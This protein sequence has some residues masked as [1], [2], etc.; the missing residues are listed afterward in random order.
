MQWIEFY[1]RQAPEI[2]KMLA[3]AQA[4]GVQPPLDLWLALE[5]PETSYYHKHCMYNAGLALAQGELV[6]F[7]DSDAMLKPSFVRSLIAAFDAEEDIVLHVDEVRNADQSFHPFRHPSFEEVLGPGC[8]NWDGEKTT[9]LSD[10]RTPLLTRNYGACMC[11]QRQDLIAVGGADEHLDYMGHV[12]GPYD[13]TFRL[14]N[15]GKREVW[16]QSE[17]LYHVWHPGTD[18]GCNYIGPH[19]GRNN[20]TRALQCRLSGQIQP[21]LESPAIRTLR[22]GAGQHFDA[23]E[24]APLLL[25]QARLNT[26]IIDRNSLELSLCRQAYY[27]S[28][29]EEAVERYLALPNPPQDSGFLA[30]MGRAFSITGRTKDAEQ[31]LEN[32]L[33]QDPAQRLAH[34]AMGWLK[35][36]RGRH[37]EALRHFDQALAVRDFLTDL[38]LLEALRGRGWAACHLGRY[39]LAAAAFH[40]GVDSAHGRDHGTLAEM[41]FGLGVALL[42]QKRYGEAEE[43]LALALENA[44]AAKRFDLEGSILK[45]RNLAEALKRQKPASRL[46]A[47]LAETLCRLFI[48]G[49]QR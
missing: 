36:N 28:R 48:A 20:S 49:N 40:D 26:W 3:E 43:Q 5:A 34:S 25:D 39:D 10:H 13:M 44:R 8:I 16:H 23:Q 6:C 38:F 15:A 4:T 30:E 42:K 12:C 18:G 46:R 17:F 32:A 27:A 22:E 31:F 14:V 7:M 33:R 24:L 37:A 47:W 19:D 41:R 2:S 1:S 45:N 11:A 29:F 9:G 21:E 35:S